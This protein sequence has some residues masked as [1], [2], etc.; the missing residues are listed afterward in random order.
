MLSNLHQV[1]IQRG[2]TGGPDPPPLENHKNIGFLSNTGP[3]RLTQS[4]QA[5]IQCWAIIS[6]QR[7]AI[8]MAFRWR[9][10]DGTFLD[11]LIFGY[12]DPLTPQQ[13]KKKKR[14]QIWAPSDKSFWIRACSYTIANVVVLA[15]INRS[16]LMKSNK[17]PI[18]L[19]L[20][21]VTLSYSKYVFYIMGMTIRW[22]FVSN[23][24]TF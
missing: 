3:D 23:Y 24:A 15:I 7:N 4:Y 10:D 13:L 22:N 14:Y 1:R 18:F 5:S 8:S 17:E 20:L 6:P 21:F 9:A 11:I 12:L 16:S 2:G 19:K